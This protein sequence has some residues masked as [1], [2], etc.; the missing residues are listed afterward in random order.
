M[1]FYFLVFLNLFSSDNYQDYFLLN[2]HQKS[3]LTSLLE[4][5]K[6]YLNHFVKIH[7]NVVEQEWNLGQLWELGKSDIKCLEKLDKF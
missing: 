4:K 7:Q 5:L 1:K 2:D 6:G 3:F